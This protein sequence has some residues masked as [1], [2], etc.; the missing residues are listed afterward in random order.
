MGVKAAGRAAKRAGEENV[1]AR[2]KHAGQ[3][4]GVKKTGQAEKPSKVLQTQ[5]SLK[6]PG[7]QTGHTRIAAKPKS[8]R[9]QPEEKEAEK[10]EE[11]Q[12]EE[13]EEAE[14][15]DDSEGEDSDDED[16]LH[17]LSDADSS[18]EDDEGDEHVG[19]ITKSGVVK[20]PS[21][22][23]DAV[24]KSR[25]D[26]VHKKKKESGRVSSPLLAGRTER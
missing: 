16:I 23:D 25:L 2:K 22:R 11:E 20:L 4:N 24:V 15:A 14:G 21:S 12:Q 17:G 18:D 6:Q 13:E 9:V 3:A 19:E 10:A 1:A 26:T 8:A 5:S 7:K